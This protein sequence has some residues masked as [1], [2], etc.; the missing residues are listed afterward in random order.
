[1]LERY[2]KHLLRPGQILVLMVAAVGFGVYFQ[3]QQIGGLPEEGKDLGNHIRR[4]DITLE[5]LAQEVAD[6]ETQVTELEAQE[7]PQPFPSQ[8]EA[9]NL[10]PALSAY[11]VDNGL[12]LLNFNTSRR[13]IPIS[14]EEQRPVVSYLDCSRRCRF[15]YGLARACGRSGHRRGSG[16][17]ILLGAGTSV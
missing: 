4:R 17:G 10:G 6:L 9:T 11:V 1:M 8:V 14:E 3:G 16:V 2:K 13:V 5:D 7:F 15:A 12:K